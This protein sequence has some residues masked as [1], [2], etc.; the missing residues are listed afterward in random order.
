MKYWSWGRFEMAILEITVIPIGTDS[1]SVSSFVAECHK[2]LKEENEIK[3]QLTPMGTVI[4]GQLET[5]FEVAKK[6]HEVPFQKGVQRVATMI[7]I[8][9]RRDRIG[10]LEQKVQS[11]QEKL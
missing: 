1:T 5:L 3:Y 10:T 7:K 6:L 4:E 11:V 8:D 9:D 2:V